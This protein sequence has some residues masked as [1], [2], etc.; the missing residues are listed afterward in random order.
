[1]KIKQILLIFLLFPLFVLSQSKTVT[2]LVNDENGSPL[3]GATVQLKGSETIGAI[4]DFDGNFSISIPSDS[5]QVLVVSYI[6]YL[7][8]EV[9]V[10]NQISIN[11]NLQ[12]DTEALEEVV[13]VGYGTVLKR[14]LTGSV[15]SVKVEDDVSRAAATVDQ[16]LQGRASGVQVTQNAANPNSGVSVR[17]R[18]T[19]SLRGNNEPLYVVDGVIISSAGEDVGAVGTG[20]TGQDPQSGLNGIN[21]RDIER[22]EILKDASATAIYGSRG[23]N[24]VVLITTKSGSQEDGK[25]KFN[26][27]FTST[28]TDITKTY[29]MLDGVGYANYSNAAR[30]AAGESPRYRVEGGNVFSYL[31]NPDGTPSDTVDNTANEL[32]DWQDYI[33]NQGISSNLGVTFSGASDSG[34]YYLSAGFNDMNGLIDNASFQTTDLRLNLNYDI[35]EKLRVEARLSTFF[36]ESDFAEGG[37]LIGGDQSFVQQTVSYNPI[38]ANGLEDVSDFFDGNVL[39]NPIAWI[40]DFTDESKENRVIASLAVKYKFNVPGL[41]YEFRV[42]GNLRDK[43]RSRFYGLTTWQGANSNGLFQQMKL[44]ALTYQVNNFLR[45]N[46]NINRNHR[47]NATLGV[48]YDVRDVSSS[49]YAVQDFVTAQLGTD[50]PFLGQVISNPLLLRAADQQMFSLLGRVN[51]TFK[52]KYVLTASFRRDGVS[53]FSENNR[54]GFFPSFAFAWRAGSEKFIQNLDLFS[55]LKFRAGWGQIG[56]HGIGPYGTLPN[57]GASSSLYGTPTNGTTVPIVLNNIPNPDLTWETTEQI[58]IG[59]DFGFNNGKISG[60]IDVYE[61]N[62][63]DLLQQTPIPTSSGFSNMLINRGT[64]ENKGVELGL[65]VTVIDKGDLNLSFGGNIAFNKTKIENLGLIAGDI[66]MPFESVNQGS[67]YGVQQI[68]S[69]LGNTPSRG[70]SIKFPINIFLEGHETALFYGWKTDGIFKSGD[71]MYRINGSMSQPGDIKVLDLNGDGQV[72]LNDRTII[73]NPNPDYIYGF[74]MN[75][76]Y[77]GFSLRALFNGTEGNDI[78]NGNMYRF[79]YAEGTY[80]N[81]IKE[82]W[83]DRWSAENPNGTYPRLGYSSNLFAAAMDRFVEDGSYLRL[84]NITLNYD[85]PLKP[86]NFIDS[87]NVY[88]TGTNLFTWTDYSGYDPEITTF[89]YDG[90]IQGVD[91]NNKPNSKSVLV[92]VNLTF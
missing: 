88:V 14:D 85:V 72:D 67:G 24:G 43:D 35:N 84:K 70:N 37:D 73:G 81:I 83:T 47:V 21:P 28:V 69:Y 53:K 12:P 31:T 3:P 41:Q 20:N 30:A 54:Y 52:N 60:T 1:M 75:L 86:D 15:S 45:Y 11:V 38:I 16:L 59:V 58:N 89:M 39:S 71:T 62:T 44:N 77:K 61:K 18:G 13:V 57:Y 65:D 2:G 92:G 48:T 64:L 49:T 50:Q 80:R 90:L 17:I 7:N 42:G 46:R 4:T 91:W 87:A 22:I 25:G 9:D 8:E 5:Q 10:T 63:K 29:D 23:A 27:Y 76:S 40:D 79:G 33:Y 36:S 56:N 51:Y 26:I 6:G 68:P 19:N 34:D 74:N 32:Y 82:A 66:L 78:V 55:S